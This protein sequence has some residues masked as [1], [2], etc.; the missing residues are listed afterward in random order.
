MTRKQSL[1]PPAVICS[2][3]LDPTLENLRQRL[4]E[5]HQTLKNAER[6]L[7]ESKLAYREAALLAILERGI[8]GDIEALRWLA[9][10]DVVDLPL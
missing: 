6:V 3:A 1:Q 8:K 7:S 4:I 2:V 5:P 9:D 10:K